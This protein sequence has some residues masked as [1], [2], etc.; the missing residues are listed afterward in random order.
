M[1]RYNVFYFMDLSATG[2]CNLPDVLH[3]LIFSHRIIEALSELIPPGIGHRRH[4]TGS[5]VD[6]LYRVGF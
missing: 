3:L 5:V 4:R 2:G 6:Y 1:K